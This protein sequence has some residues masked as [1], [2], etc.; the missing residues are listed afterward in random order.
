MM[1]LILPP[2][3]PYQTTATIIYQAGVLI[4]KDTLQSV[5]TLFRKLFLCSDSLFFLQLI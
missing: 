4:P 3:T 2:T 1:H 5:K